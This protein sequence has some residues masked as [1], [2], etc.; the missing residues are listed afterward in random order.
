M[1]RKEGKARWVYECIPCD[2]RVEAF[3]QFRAVEYGR[4]HEK[5]A[6]HGQVMFGEALSRAWDALSAIITPAI[7]AA[8]EFGRIFEPP[9]NLPHDPS[10][11][12]DRRK[13]GGR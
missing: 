13:W 2:N 1:I 8:A 5:T 4:W 6:G 12:S 10:L 7:E 3:D 9:K 11:L